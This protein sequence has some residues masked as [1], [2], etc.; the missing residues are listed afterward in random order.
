MQADLVRAQVRKE[1]KKGCPMRHPFF[2]CVPLAGRA[3]SA[4]A[5]LAPTTLKPPST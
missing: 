4:S 3:Y 5:T 2:I 1:Q